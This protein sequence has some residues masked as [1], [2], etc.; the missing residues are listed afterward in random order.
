MLTRTETHMEFI[1]LL[2]II[3][4]IFLVAGAGWRAIRR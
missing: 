3:F 1:W 4:V 2:L